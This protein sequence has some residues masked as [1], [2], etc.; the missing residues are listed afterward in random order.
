M[1]KTKL[2]G[3]DY[4]TFKLCKGFTLCP[5][6]QTYATIRGLEFRVQATIARST[7]DARILHLLD[8]PSPASFGPHPTRCLHPFRYEGPTRPTAA[9][10]RRREVRREAASSQRKGVAEQRNFLCRG[11]YHQCGQADVTLCH[12]WAACY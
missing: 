7:S 4:I 10:L 5:E 11:D 2:D 3:V 6:V 1:Y 8:L 12:G 9:R